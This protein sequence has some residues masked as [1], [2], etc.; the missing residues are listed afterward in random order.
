MD[1]V[2]QAKVVISDCHLSAGRF[3]EGKL[4]VHEDFFF[5]EEMVDLFNHFSSGQYGSGP[6]GPLPVE[7]IIN[8]DFFDYLNV[9]YQGEFE[10]AI[11][12][13]IALYKTEAII[14]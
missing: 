9:P 1:F 4:N 7:L 2:D 12:E 14:Q 3:F 8:G 6:D 11:T 10:D 5:D 13:E